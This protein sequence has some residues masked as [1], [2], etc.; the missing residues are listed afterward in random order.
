LR[1]WGIGRSSSERLL[2]QG[3]F[4]LIFLHEMEM[5]LGVGVCGALLTSI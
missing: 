4:S 5:V 1:G 2:L 3:G